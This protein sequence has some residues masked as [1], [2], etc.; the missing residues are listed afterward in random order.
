MEKQEN[1]VVEVLTEVKNSGNLIQ[2]LEDKLVESMNNSKDSLE[3][4]LVDLT[5]RTTDDNL[6]TEINL[7]G[8][9]LDDIH[10]KFSQVNYD[11]INENLAK[12]TNHLNSSGDILQKY[13]S[14]LAEYDNKF[15][16]FR[17]NYDLQFNQ[18]AKTLQCE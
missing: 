3:D 14:K 6:T 8:L 13:E 1:D 4:K 12:I 17:S 15:E 11:E 9:S 10:D 7:I 2:N 18:H 5:N 16:S